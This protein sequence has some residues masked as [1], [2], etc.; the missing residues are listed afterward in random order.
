MHLCVIFL[1]LTY[2][3]ALEEL[4]SRRF[5]TALALLSVSPDISAQP[6]PNW[7]HQQLRASTL[8]AVGRFEDAAVVYGELMQHARQKA[9]HTVARRRIRASKLFSQGKY[10]SSVDELTIALRYGREAA[11]LYRLRGEAH[12]HLLDVRAAHSDASLSYML[13]PHEPSALLLLARVLYATLGP[14]ELPV[15]SARRC[16]R[17]APDHVGCG[18]LARWLSS[19]AEQ[20][21]QAQQLERTGAIE[22]AAA[23]YERVVFRHAPDRSDR[24]HAHGPAHGDDGRQPMPRTLTKQV[25]TSLC[26]LQ[27][28]LGDAK[29][30]IAACAVAV[31]LVGQ[32]EADAAERIDGAEAHLHTAWAQ[33]LVSATDGVGKARYAVRFAE[34]LLKP[35]GVTLGDE[36]ER[37]SARQMR[38][39]LEELKREI[40]RVE[41]RLEQLLRLDLYAVVRAAEF[42][43]L[44]VWANRAIT[45]VVLAGQMWHA[46]CASCAHPQ[47]RCASP[48]ATS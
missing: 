22:R 40:T 14:D 47:L 33:L 19:V 8:M 46:A 1:A 24:S 16:V 42:E 17:I 10:A 18:R 9:A 35:V 13:A 29:A 30:C 5:E 6:L 27:K 34:S 43:S 15:K 20:Y 2:R 32:A 7:T 48:V 31:R 45:C 11:P 21:A 28:R 39:L 23:G 4:R 44:R 41:A 12:L 25:Y 37:E 3:D 26:R 38:R 36:P